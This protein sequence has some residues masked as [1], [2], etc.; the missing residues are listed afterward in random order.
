MQ[1]SELSTY[2]LLV[3]LLYCGKGGIHPQLEPIN[4]NTLLAELRTRAGKDLG[5]EPRTWIAWFLLSTTEGSSE[6]KGSIQTIQK[7]VNIERKNLGKLFP[8]QERGN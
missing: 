3:E 2:H 7:I 8:N 4:T 5:D 6:E 1:I